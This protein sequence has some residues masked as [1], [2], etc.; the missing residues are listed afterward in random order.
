MKIL[1]KGSKLYSISKNKCPRCHE[2]LFW[3]YPPV[4]N[5]IHNN[6]DLTKN[7]SYCD[8]KFEIELG[9][10]YGAMYVSYALGVGLILII[11]LLQ[12]I[13]FPSID[14]M[15]LIFFITISV[16]LFSPYNFFF[17][18]LIWINF[19]VGFSSDRLNKNGEN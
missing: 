2:G 5:L 4:K 10:W 6:G 15:S 14:V 11:C 12:F 9:F 7:C 3:P 19:F 18:R 13:L 1:K 16:I 17:S 8:L